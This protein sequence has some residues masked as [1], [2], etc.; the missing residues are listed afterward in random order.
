MELNGFTDQGTCEIWIGSAVDESGFP[1]W[2]RRFVFNHISLN[3]V[4]P[5]RFVHGFMY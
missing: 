2:V 3:A 5:Q 1:S 4:A